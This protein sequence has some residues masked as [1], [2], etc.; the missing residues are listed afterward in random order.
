MK[1]TK[2][3]TSGVFEPV[4]VTNNE[5]ELSLPTHS[6]HIRNNGIEFLSSKEVPMWTELNVDLQAATEDGRIQCTGIVVGCSGNKH[7][8]Y[9]VSIIFMG[10]T[11]EAQERLTTL[12]EAQPAL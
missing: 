7:N 11:P 1:T 8:G 4:K 2:L 10:I 9:V 12:V 3:D 5:L 6:V